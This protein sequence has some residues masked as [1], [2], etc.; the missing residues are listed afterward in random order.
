MTSR[1]ADTSV[2]VHPLIAARWS[3]RAL[4]PVGEVSDDA[5]RAVLEAARWAPSN[6]NTQP[7]RFLVGR[8][9]D[10]THKRLFSLLSK[11]NQQ[12]AHAAAVLMLACAVTV[13]EKG[14]V[15]MPDY[16]VALAVQN[17]VL[18]AV[19]EGLVAHQMGGFNRDGAPL[20]FSLP[21]DVRPVVMVALGTL[22]S[23]DL[24]D[25]EQRAKELRP[26]RRLPLEQLAFTGEWG[27][28]VF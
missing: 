14:E 9:G 26:R 17:L 25:D 22:G 11:R 5:L 16:G 21:T 13:N 23:P 6:G 19:S 20:V 2:P 28:P 27:N 10:E 4:D 7:A 8:R 24:L 18:Q 12:W 3:P 15:P 1:D